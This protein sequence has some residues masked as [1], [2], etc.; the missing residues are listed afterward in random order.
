MQKAFSITLRQIAAQLGGELHGD[1]EK[2]I[3]GFCP[4]NEPCSEDIAYVAKSSLKGIDAKLFG[5]IL[6]PLNITL[7]EKS[8]GNF[9]KVK[10]PYEALVSLIPLFTH[11]RTPPLGIHEKADVAASA[12]IGVGV[13]IGAF[14]SIGDDTVI[15]D[16]CRIYPHVTIYPGAQIGAYSII[17]SGAVIRED[18]ILGEYSV[19]QN[20]AVIGSD[21][22][23]Y[24]PDPKLGLRAIPQVGNVVTQERVEVGANACIDRATLGST[25]IGVGTKIDNLVQ[26]GHNVHIGMHSVICGQA[27]IA[28][29]AK[30]GNQVVLGGNAGVADHIILGDKV[31]LAAKSGA[32]E[33]IPL[34][35]DYGGYPPVPI[36][37]Y[38]RNQVVHKKLAETIK[39]LKDKLKKSD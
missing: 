29:S 7:D 36:G 3:S 9:I 30:I 38:Q 34:P 22:F 39:E 32:I 19:V 26:I 12:Q 31:R 25:K 14:V 35:G 8:S 33:N 10:D 2:T 4:L 1:P 27:G 24:V 20:G 6:V 15:G 18:V 23:G 21:G 28:G 5:A 16:Y 11:T 37:A 13:S 17:H